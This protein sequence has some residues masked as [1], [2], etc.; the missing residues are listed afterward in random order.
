MNNYNFINKD[1]LNIFSILAKESRKEL[2]FYLTIEELTKLLPYGRT[3]IYELLNN[4]KIPSRKVE[5][6]WIIPRDKFLAWFYG[7]LNDFD[8]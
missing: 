8:Y 6:K 2:P 5:G 7:E 1:P 3:K 4:G